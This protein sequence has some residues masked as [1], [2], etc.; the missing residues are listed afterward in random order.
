MKNGTNRFAQI[1]IGGD[2][3]FANFDLELGV[4]GTKHQFVESSMVPAEDE[5]YRCSMG[6]T[7]PNGL[8]FVVYL[9]TA[10]NVVRAQGN[11]TTGS[12]FLCFPKF[13]I[14]QVATSYIPTNGTRVT[15]AADVILSD[16]AMSLFR[17]YGVRDF[18][19]P[20]GRRGLLGAY[21]APGEKGDTG[22]PGPAGAKGDP[23]VA[24]A[25]GDT[26]SQG[27]AGAKGD[28]GVAGPKGDTGDPG[29]AGAKGDLGVAGVDGVSPDAPG[30]VATTTYTGF[31]GV[32]TNIASFPLTIT[33][34]IPKTNLIKYELGT[35]SPQQAPRDWRWP[36][37]T[38]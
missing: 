36:S 10:A 34:T 4:L 17:L 35:G 7:S 2:G 11:T 38:N 18:F 16:V 3:I 37:S 20:M 25:K 31:E 5:W 30:W 9:V 8:S 29:P 23:G 19:G 33:A 22:E 27:P 28:P 13:K 12:I 14:G 24:G 6:I 21:G 32:W 26:G 15:R 1:S